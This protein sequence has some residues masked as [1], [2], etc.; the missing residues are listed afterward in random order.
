MDTKPIEIK[1]NGTSRPTLQRQAHT[2]SL[3]DT[4]SIFKL[5]NQARA[6][7]LPL[8]KAANHKEFM[9]FFAWGDPDR[10]PQKKQEAKVSLSTLLSYS[11]R[12]EKWLMALGIFMVNNFSTSVPIVSYYGDSVCSYFDCN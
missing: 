6:D 1:S 5:Y 8:S 3:N 2:R 9:S 7:A 10:D 4:N 11:T 12:K